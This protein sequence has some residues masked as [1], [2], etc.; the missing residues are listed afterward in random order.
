[1]H[2]SFSLFLFPSLLFKQQR[3]GWHKNS[4][5]RS[6]SGSASSNSN[7]NNNQ[8]WGIGQIRLE[9]RA[10]LWRRAPPTRES[11]STLPTFVRLREWER[12]RECVRDCATERPNFLCS[13]NPR[14][15]EK[16]Q[17]KNKGRK[18]ILNFHSFCVIF[19]WMNKFLLLLLLLLLF[20]SCSVSVWQQQ[21][22]PML[23]LKMNLESWKD[24]KIF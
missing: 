15:S 23:Q 21:Q 14:K 17:Q 2:L 8:D 5:S 10:W 24:V 9:S 19:R 6:R 11:P 18:E 12:E 13:V 16:V 3:R 22:P 1:M 4:R 20:L 7:N